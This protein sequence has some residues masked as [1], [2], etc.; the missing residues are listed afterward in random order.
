[1]RFESRETELGRWGNLAEAPDVNRTKAY[2]L[3]DVDV[4]ML[5]LPPMLY[6]M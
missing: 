4:S 6:E 3:V 1:M 2:Q 5:T